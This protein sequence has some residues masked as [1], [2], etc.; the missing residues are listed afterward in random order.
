[1]DNNEYKFSL[2]SLQK[3]FETGFRSGFI[4]ASSNPPEMGKAVGF[5]E[6]VKN[7]FDIVLYSQEITTQVQESKTVAALNYAEETGK[8]PN[9]WSVK[10]NRVQAFIAGVDWSNTNRLSEETTPDLLVMCITE[11]DEHSPW[12]PGVNC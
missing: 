8:F 11:P 1:M 9:S 6:W 4:E 2:Q 10:R 12:I 5:E 7:T 3:A